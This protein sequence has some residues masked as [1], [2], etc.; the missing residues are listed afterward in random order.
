MCNI[1]ANF[2]QLTLTKNK[3][4]HLRNWCSNFA[5]A[6]RKPSRNIE[7]TYLRRWSVRSTIT[8]PHKRPCCNMFAGRWAIR[9]MVIMYDAW[10]T[11]DRCDRFWMVNRWHR[12]ATSKM[13]QVTKSFKSM[14]RKNWNTVPLKSFVQVTIV[15]TKHA[16]FLAQIYDAARNNAKKS[17]QFTFSIW[18]KI[19]VIF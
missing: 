15:H 9:H 7:N 8:H 1:S 4:V 11:R 19:C 17:F 16:V 18:P 10:K 13:D 14:Q 12:R 5:T 2:S 3:L 6:P